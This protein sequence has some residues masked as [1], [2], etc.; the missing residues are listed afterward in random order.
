MNKTIIKDRDDIL[1]KIFIFGPFVIAVLIGLFLGIQW[2]E[3][4]EPNPYTRTTFFI[5]L[6]VSI[7]YL[8]V[9]NSSIIKRVVDYMK[10]IGYAIVSKQDKGEAVDILDKRYIWANMM[11]RIGNFNINK[12]DRTI[13]KSATYLENMVIKIDKINSKL[14]PKINKFSKRLNIWEGLKNWKIFYNKF[15]KKLIDTKVRI[16]EEKFNKYD[17]ILT[18]TNNMADAIQSGNVELVR[19]LDN[20][21]NK[22]VNV[23]FNMIRPESIISKSIEDSRDGLL[24]RLTNSRFWIILTTYIL[25]IMASILFGYYFIFKYTYGGYEFKAEYLSTL[26]VVMIPYLARAITLV[27][28]ARIEFNIQLRELEYFCGVLDYIELLSKKNNIVFSNKLIVDKE[29]IKD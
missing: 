9:F 4:T 29:T 22:I 12:Y 3:I 20:E 25:P 14:Q 10:R 23:K 6:A 26:F 16:Y 11:T 24:K 17:L 19:K 15:T 5:S 28:S 8:P 2:N 7:A 13:I 27:S 21:I 18:E 1:S